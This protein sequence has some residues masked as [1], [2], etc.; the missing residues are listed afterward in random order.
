M[1]NVLV[2]LD[3]IIAKKLLDRMIET[4]TGNNMY[5]IVYINDYILPEQR[6]SNFTF[7]KFDPTSS[8]KLKFVLDKVT[9]NEALVV[10]NNK[11]DTLA[12]IANIR[13]RRKNFYF[14]VYDNWDLDNLDTKI[15]YYKGNEILANG[16]LEKLPNIPVLAQNIGLGQGEIM[17][18]KIPFGSS[19]A[20]RYIGSIRQKD[21]KIFA[22][23]RNQS[24]I[25][26]KSSL[27]LK[28]NDIILVIGKPD[29]LTQVYSAISQTAGHFPMPFGSCIYVYC[30]LFIQNDNEVCDAIKKAKFLHQRI[31]NK[32]FIVKIT[33]P[34]TV[35]IVDKIKN[36]LYN[37][38][39]TILEI[40]YKNSGINA[41]LKED[42]KR[43]DIG[44]IFLTNS[45]LNYKEAI[46]NII[47]FKIP[48]F[49][50]G[51]ESINLIKNTVIVLN[52]ITNY[53]Q[54]SPIVFDIS[55]QLKLRIKIFDLD[56][57]GN[58]EQSGLIEHLENLSKIFNQDI[59]IISNNNNPIIQLQKEQN[60]LQILPLKEAMFDRRRIKFFNTNSDLLAFD[61]IKY[62]QLLIPIVED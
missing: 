55:K 23:Y 24:M 56:P 49:K 38:Q 15:N 40:D 32:I 39:N 21:W 58:K 44:L 14:T 27:V 5:D 8:F 46:R 30:D 2:I 48:I 43:F 4:N 13:A 1:K 3:G 12:V 42:K 19:Y 61:L 60:I 22:L 28:P 31:K 57:I 18:I 11:D 33:R 6:P 29:I 7:Y 45:L 16:L 34:T 35:D 62:N 9:H 10:L 47:E 37:C 17:E 25:N 53:E 59:Q 52:E 20:Y 36:L 50:I 51:L 54:L 26:V 41:I